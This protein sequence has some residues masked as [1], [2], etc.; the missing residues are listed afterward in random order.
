MQNGQ[1][2]CSPE[3]VIYRLEG[4]E[5]NSYNDTGKTEV[6]IRKEE[7]E[8]CKDGIKVRIGPHSVNVIQ[9]GAV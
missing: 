5:P 1:V 4:K 7:L 3:S 9:I 2:S 6:F 8:T